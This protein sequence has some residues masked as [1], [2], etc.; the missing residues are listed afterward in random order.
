MTDSGTAGL[1]R[2]PYDALAQAKELFPFGS[3]RGACDVDAWTSF[4]FASLVTVATAPDGSPILLLS[5]LAAHTRHLEADPG[6]RCCL[7][8]PA[9]A[10][11]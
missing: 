11:R 1:S 8:K 3:R 7:R 5:R 4:P 10:I 9:R 2:E 6:F